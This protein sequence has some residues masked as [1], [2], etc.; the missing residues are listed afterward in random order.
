MGA[1]DPGSR[2][3]LRLYVAGGSPNSVQA[4][5]NLDAICKGPLGGR[6]SVEIVDVLKD[7]LRLF[8]DGILVTPTLVRLSPAPVVKVVG[9]LS[10]TRSVL[11]A[12]GEDGAA[13]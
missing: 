10:A 13:P 7:P 9:N 3:I 1:P 12:L 8:R 6:P 5:A 11:D 2:L 4:R